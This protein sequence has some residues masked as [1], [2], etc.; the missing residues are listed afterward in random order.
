MNAKS[1]NSNVIFKRSIGCLS[2]FTLLSSTASLGISSPEAHK[3]NSPSINYDNRPKL[4]IC[5]TASRY[6][7]TSLKSR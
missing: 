4:A 2:S 6:W 3:L 1:T 7:H 5:K